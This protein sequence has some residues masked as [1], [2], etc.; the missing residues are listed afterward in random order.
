MFDFLFNPHGRIS[1]KGYAI[2]FLLPYMV[3]AVLPG[4]FLALTGPAS[5]VLTLIG[6]FFFWP[7][8]AVSV[9]RFHDLGR[10]G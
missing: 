5:L 2:G 9:K 8:I 3:L 4:L 7:S 6:L 10:T 1:R